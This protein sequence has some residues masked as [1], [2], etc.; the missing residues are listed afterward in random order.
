MEIFSDVLHGSYGNDEVL[1]EMQA[2][3]KPY[4]FSKHSGWEPDNHSLSDPSF[5]SNCLMDNEVPLFKEFLN[6]IFSQYMEMLNHSQDTIGGW[7]ITESW[8]TH[9]VHNE[10]ARMHQH[11]TTDVSGVYY[12][13]S[14]PE[15]DGN[16]YFYT[17]EA[18]RI[19]KNLYRML[20]AQFDVPAEE[21]KLILFPG[22]L[23][24]G[25]RLHKGDTPRISVSFNISIDFKS[26]PQINKFT[27]NP[28]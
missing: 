10:Y 21:N 18:M 6:A 13:Q 7:A 23:P 25:T 28:N 1:K 3:A 8:L 9:T 17:P 19:A 20:P 14:K 16:I 26:V 15:T 24:H 27:K 12:I 2:M 11:G 5:K 4:E 22:W